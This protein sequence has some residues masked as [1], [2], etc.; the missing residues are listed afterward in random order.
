MKKHDKIRIYMRNQSIIF[1]R[2]KDAFGGLSNMASG[3][4]ILI[5]NIKV[6]SSEA[7]YQACRFP[8]LVDVQKMII[9]QK[10]PMIA[11]MKSK[12]FRS[13]TRADWDDVRV[14]IMRWCLRAKLACNWRKI[15]E[16]LLATGD[17]PIVED[18]HRDYFWGAVPQDDG[19]LK[20]ENILGRLLIELREELKRDKQ[21]KL[22][23]VLLPNIINFNLLGSPIPVLRANIDSLENK[24]VQKKRRDKVN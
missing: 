13:Q 6:R 18:S 22:K 10:I 5:G 23:T 12:P 9:E 16:L 1:R 17:K 2:T 8:S 15:G 19:S 7:L 3:Y 21:Q 4:D 14:P 24:D 20:G 11:K